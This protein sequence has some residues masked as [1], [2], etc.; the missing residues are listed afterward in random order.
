MT[1]GLAAA[2]VAVLGAGLALAGGVKTKVTAGLKAGPSGDAIAGTVKSEEKVC[3]KG[4]K[5][6]VTYQDAPAPK[7][8]I[9]TDEADKKGKYSVPFA[10]GGFAPP[11]TYTAT[12]KKVK[13]DGVTCKEGVGTYEHF[14][15]PGPGPGPEG[16]H[17]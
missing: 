14:G 4:R 7:Q 2:L 9:G 8:T 5:V 6:K 16:D 11:G 13:V 3:V 17:G 15:G 10:N 1:A 12:A